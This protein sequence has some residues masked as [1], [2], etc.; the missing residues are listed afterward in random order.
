M[1]KIDNFLRLRRL[2]AHQANV[3][4]QILVNS[5]KK[6]PKCLSFSSKNT[7]IVAR[8]FGARLYVSIAGSNI[9][10]QYNQKLQKSCLG[11]KIGA[12]LYAPF[13]NVSRSDSIQ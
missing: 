5:D 11:A 8:A 3:F 12:T 4:A 13:V 10:A 7:K 6:S 9:C 2:S 1:A